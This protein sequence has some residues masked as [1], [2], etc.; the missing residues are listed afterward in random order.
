MTSDHEGH[1]MIL[2]EAM[3]IKTPIIAHTVGGIPE[4]LDHGKCGTLIN[5]H[6]ASAFAQTIIELIK[7]P[8]TIIFII[9]IYQFDK[10]ERLFACIGIL[11][12]KS[13]NS[14]YF[15]Q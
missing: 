2:L 9:W 14:V 15:R 12:L 7:K 8:G 10:N 11:R 6:T 1:P 4:L 13:A 5:T 3:C